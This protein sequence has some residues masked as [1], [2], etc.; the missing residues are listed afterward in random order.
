MPEPAAPTSSGGAA[1][2]LVA[3]IRGALALETGAAPLAGAGWP[4]SEVGTDVVELAAAHRVI[5]LLASAAGSFPVGGPAR[6]L[7]QGLEEQSAFGALRLA[8]ATARVSSALAHAGVD[9]LVYK[10]IPLSVQT[11]GSITSRGWGDVDL[12]VAPQRVAQAHEALLAAGGSFLPRSVPEPGSPL[13]RHAARVRA[14]APYR[15]DD[16][17]IDLHWRVDVSARVMSTQ[18]PGLW[19]RREDV[20]VAGAVVPTLGRRDALLVTAVHGTKEHWRQL[21]WV[22]DAARQ[23]RA[24]PGHQWDAVRHEA[25]EAGALP[26]IGVMLGVAGRLLPPDPARPRPTERARRIADGVWRE[27]LEGTAP[28]HV[29]DGR[30]QLAKVSFA[31]RTAPG[32]RARFDHLR[33][34][35]VAAEDMAVLP[36]P[37]VMVPLYLPLRPVLRRRRRRY[38]ARIEGTP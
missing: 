9:H 22:V 25:R 24:V 8:R 13:W 19:D 16:V 37:E 2:A 15:W 30:S 17:D 18:F 10:G 36:L 32:A 14:E 31:W 26:G 38:A 35:F 12:L 20:T 33:A 29:W 7:L 4:P 28:F 27:C 5:P 11:T 23:V 3:W 34:A 21:R 1:E 6:D